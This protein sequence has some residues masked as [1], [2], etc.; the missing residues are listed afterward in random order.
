[1]FQPVAGSESLLAGSTDPGDDRGLSDLG[2]AFLA[3]LIALSEG[4]PGPR[5]ILDLA[6]L[7]AR[8]TA[9]VLRWL[10]DNAVP[11][12]RLPLVVSHATTDYRKTLE[13]STPAHRSL[14]E[15]RARGVVI[16]LTPGW[17]GCETADEFRRLIEIVAALPFGG[18]A[19]TEGIAIGTDFLRFERTAPAL[20]SAR[21]I[22]RWLGRAFDGPSA[23][24]IGSGSARRLL[25][26]V[27]H[28]TAEM[29]DENDHRVTS[30]GS[31]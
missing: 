18:R 10:D 4:G 28:Q 20:S 26:G 3:R 15:L 23:A 25:L 17:P 11:A 5:L 7:N 2:R 22:V 27:S 21:E 6:G 30:A 24:A 1:V 31:G 14:R 19:G 29:A 12:S 16:G 8:S 13:E 9:E